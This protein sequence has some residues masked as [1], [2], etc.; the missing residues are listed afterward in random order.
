MGK[1][2]FSVTV[3]IPAINEAA[4]LSKLAPQ[5]KHH[6]VLLIDGGSVD[7]T[8]IIAKRAGFKIIHEKR[9]GY[10]RAYKTAIENV[11]TEYIACIDADGTYLP[12][13]VEKAI[14]LIS[15]TGA[16]GIFGDRFG[17]ADN[18]NSY[19]RL[20]GNLAITLFINLLF[21]VRLPD[22]QTGFWVLRTSAA[23][24]ALPV[25]DGMPFSQELKLRLLHSGA[26]VVWM[27]IHYIDRPM[28]G[29]KFNFLPDGIRLLCNALALRFHI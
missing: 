13:D 11:K 8:L 27:P 29:S 24:R 19:A 25:S 2:P 14:S 3:V 6:P 20:L 9:R 5:L 21:N 10:G 22:S 26:R 16:D 4:G 7:G 18:H 28:P 15:K 1:K 23:R 17:Y 12:S